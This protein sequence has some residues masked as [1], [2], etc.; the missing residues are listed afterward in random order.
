MDTII[1]VIIIAGVVLLATALLIGL[2]SG[3]LSFP[4]LQFY[5]KGKESGFKLREINL[6][7]RIALSTKVREP[8]SLFWSA[9]ILDKC[10]GS[11][12][13]DM[14]RNNTLESLNGARFIRQ[15]FDLRAHLDT[16]QN[17][18][19]GIERSREIASGQQLTIIFPSIGAFQTRV[20]ENNRRH[21]AIAYPEGTLPPGAEWL[22]QH[23]AIRFWRSEDAEYSFTTTVSGDFHTQGYHLLHIDHSSKLNRLQRRKAG[24]TAINQPARIY[25]LVTATDGS[26]EFRLTGGY[27]CRLLN[28]STGG[29]AL[30]VGGKI[31]IGQPVQLQCEASGIQIVM[32]GVVKGQDYKPGKN[33][34]IA[35]IEARRPSAVMHNR[36]QMLVFGISLSNS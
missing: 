8:T 21:I 5:I 20:V 13:V 28:I 22:N 26:E 11:L 18:R 17:Q 32:R 30:L 2:R 9:R 35:H 27:R 16:T 34:T 4:W 33:V 12:I 19:I 24:R 1:I 15:L 31:R 29:A 10:L 25:N 3:L 14:R 23:T 36:I 6:L 7:R